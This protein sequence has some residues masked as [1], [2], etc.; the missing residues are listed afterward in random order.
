[1]QQRGLVERHGDPRD[2]RA[3]RVALTEAGEHLI[4][5]LVAL[6]RQ[7]LRRLGDLMRPPV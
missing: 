3:V 6:H 1:V 5:R 7:E 4:G 2:G